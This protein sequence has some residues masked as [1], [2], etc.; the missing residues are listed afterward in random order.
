M[1]YNK[2]NAER[3]LVTFA[4][5][6]YASLFKQIIVSA[7]L[8]KKVSPKSFLLLSSPLASEHSAFSLTEVS[9]SEVPHSW[10]NSSRKKRRRWPLFWNCLDTQAVLMWHHSVQLKVGGKEKN[11]QWLG[12]LHKV[13]KIYLSKRVST[14][15]SSVLLNRSLEEVWLDII[16]LTS[17]QVKRFVGSHLDKIS[18]TEWYHEN[19]T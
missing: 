11:L 8:Q 3:L 7:P 5:I 4:V 19:A 9:A 1:G 2:L 6:F 13:R 17:I 16:W 12:I 18:R 10:W 14:P 15:L